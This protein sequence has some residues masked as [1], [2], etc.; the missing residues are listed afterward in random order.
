MMHYEWCLQ[1]LRGQPD[2]TD[3]LTGGRKLLL[4][5]VM[6]VIKDTISAICQVY[7]VLAD[8]NSLQS[9]ILG[10]TIAVFLEFLTLFV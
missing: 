5:P 1:K 4:L 7:L 8:Q 3:I 9:L 2:V 10:Q 6:I